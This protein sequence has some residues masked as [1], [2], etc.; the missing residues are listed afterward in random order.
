MGNAGRNGGTTRPL[1]NAIVQVINP[2]IGEKR[3][4]GAVGSAG[5]CSSL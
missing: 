3:Y 4:D 1:I 5:F 2:K